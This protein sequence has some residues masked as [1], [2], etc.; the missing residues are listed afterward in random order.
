MEKPHMAILAS[1]R[2]GWRGERKE[3]GYGFFFHGIFGVWYFARTKLKPSRHRDGNKQT[4]P[5]F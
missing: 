3:R 4:Q 5:V 2:E 1:P